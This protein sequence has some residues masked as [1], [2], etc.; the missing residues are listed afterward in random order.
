MNHMGMS[1]LIVGDASWTLSLPSADSSSAI[2]LD[3][4]VV[5]C[6]PRSRGR[7]PASSPVRANIRNAGVPLIGTGPVSAPPWCRRRS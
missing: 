2:E 3:E 5:I 6:T 4:P 7:S 1:A